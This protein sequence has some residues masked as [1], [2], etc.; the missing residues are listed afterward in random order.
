MVLSVVILRATA[1][2]LHSGTGIL[3][4]LDELVQTPEMDLGFDCGPSLQ[5]LCSCPK[6][7]KRRFASENGDLLRARSLLLV[8]LSLIKLQASCRPKRAPSSFGL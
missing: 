8:I 7:M 1:G 2:N 6:V 3:D 5:I 4:S